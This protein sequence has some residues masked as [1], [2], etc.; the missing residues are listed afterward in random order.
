MLTVT[1]IDAVMAEIHYQRV[2]SNPMG[3]LYTHSNNKPVLVDINFELS[4]FPYVAYTSYQNE[5]MFRYQGVYRFI[6]RTRYEF[7][8]QID[9]FILNP[10]KIEDIQ[11]RIYGGNRTEKHLEPTPPEFNF[12]R[13]FEEVFSSKS[14]HALHPEEKY[15]DVDGHLRYV[16]FMLHRQTSNVAIELNGERYHHPIAITRERY[17]SQLTKQNSLIYD[18]TPVYRWSDRGMRDDFKFKDQLLQF[19]GEPNDFK[20]TPYFKGKRKVD[21]QLYE[22]Q[23]QAVESI[24]KKRKLGQTAFL[25]ELPTGTGKTEVFIEDY[26]LQLQQGNCYKALAVVPT[27]NLREQ[28]VKRVKAQLPCVKVSEALDDQC[29]DL[30]VTTN[31]AIVRHYQQFP[32][33][34]FDYL[35]I[36]EAHHAVAHGLSRVLEHF[37]PKTLLGLTATTELLSPKKLESIFGNFTAELT[38]EE[39][40]KRGLAPPIRVFRLESNIDFSKVRFNGKEFVKSD[41]NKTV[42]I[43]S[44]DSLI[45]DLLAKYFSSDDPTKLAKQGIVFCV[46]VK[47]TQRMAK[48][49]QAVGISAKSVHGK[50]S[51]GIDEYFAGKVQF[52]CACQLLSEGWDAPQTSVVVMA[53]PTMSKALY[54]QQL[55]RGTRLAENKEALY[56]IDIIDNYAGALLQPWNINAL[57]GIPHYTPFADLGSYDNP[58]PQTEVTVLDGLYE[59][60][61]RLEQINLFNFEKEFGDL[62]STEQVAREC[63]VSTGTITAW[64]KK[65]DITPTRS[66]PFGRSQLHYFS[67]ENVQ[68]IKAK[69]NIKPRT[70]ETRKQDFFEFLEKRDYTFSFKIIFLLAFLKCHQQNGEANSDDLASIYQN[71]YLKLHERHSKCEKDASPLN[72]LATLQD[73][74]YIKNS[75]AKNPFEKFERKRF[76]YQSSELAITSV[77]PVLWSKLNKGDLESIR[78]QMIKDGIDYFAKVGIALSADD[79][80]F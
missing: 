3:Y 9:K 75:I 77:D 64:L 14:L 63:F 1:D 18:G 12:S 47:H 50:D 4:D 38:L 27:I 51:S 33:T 11:I 23:Q 80:R 41:L 72:N 76:F 55:G 13:T 60:V 79:F 66:V 24:A 32:S 10:P 31:A 61:R 20:A 52:L 37:T 7:L 5:L 16:D 62:L 49:L 42:Q 40:V 36:D 34:Q 29:A 59:Q 30:I 6:A 70:E 43:P 73:I 46:D 56:V 58:V 53:R 15:V 35:L 26:R 25:I 57:F 21:F 68:S 78:E 44:R 39:A 71:F 17:L 28:L 45:A 67:D 54:V 2:D 22:H 74:K 69:K 19:F 8:Q 65:G 48:A